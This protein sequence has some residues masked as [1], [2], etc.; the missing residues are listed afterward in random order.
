M[1]GAARLMTM[2]IA[3]SSECAHRKITVPAKFSSLM[4]GIATSIWPSR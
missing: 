1:R 3:P 4:P 2:P